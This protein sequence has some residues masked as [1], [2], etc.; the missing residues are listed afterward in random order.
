[1]T[2]LEELK[3]LVADAFNKATDKAEID[4]NA[5]ILKKFDEVTKEQQDSQ[6]EYTDLLTSYKD[7]VLHTSVKPS[8][9]DNGTAPAV[10]NE[11]AEFNKL[12]N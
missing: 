1:M 9:T 10:F 4:R 12:F 3:A 5:Q 7:V 6:K 8:S 2:K 11:Q